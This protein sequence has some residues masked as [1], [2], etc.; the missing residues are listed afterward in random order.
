MPEPFAIDPLTQ[1]ILASP[2]LVI[3]E[4]MNPK[5]ARHL[6]DGEERDVLVRGDIAGAMRLR[7]SRSL[8]IQGEVAGT[9]VTPCRIDAEGDV[10]IL[11]AA[12]H[13]QIS[14]R[15]IYV[16]AQAEGCQFSVT[17][18]LQIGGDLHGGRAQVGV[19]QPGQA[20]IA[21]LRAQI[22]RGREERERLDRLVLQE[23]KRLDRA[24][25]TT[26]VP[27]DFNAGR[28]VRQEADRITIDL[29]S[30]YKAV[31]LLPE[32]K[33]TAALDEF[34]A[35][36][37]IGLLARTNQRYLS[38]NAARQKVFLQLL[39]QLRELFVLVTRRDQTRQLLSELAE[40]IDQLVG[41]IC[42]PRSQICVHGQVGPG[43][44]LDFVLPSAQDQGDRNFAFNA[45]SAEL[46]V[47]PGNEP[48]TLQLEL[49]CADQSHF[50]QSAAETELCCVA[51]SSLNG[52][53]FWEPLPPPTT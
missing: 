21:R 47:Q 5:Q 11:G 49:S 27:L 29:S 39:R 34:F 36:G 20:R 50:R 3:I 35:K 46:Q 45:A 52:Q 32:D 6:F 43:T 48:G 7:G 4:G 51:F 53:V 8:L 2:D 37:V 31:G 17:A 44:T 28:I 23:E 18:D 13:A 16:A 15:N 22:D 38:E 1:A 14:G 24:C 33:R 25:K 9:P 42:N 41:Q 30:F 12:R 26:L 40:A 19:Y 10:L